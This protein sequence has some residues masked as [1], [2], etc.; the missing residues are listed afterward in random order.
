MEIGVAQEGF[1]TRPGAGLSAMPPQ[2][3]IEMASLGQL[4]LPKNLM[5]VT[6]DLVK[7]IL[8]ADPNTRLE[9]KDIM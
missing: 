1:D 9:I 4:N 8:A 6:R 5:P 7:R 2:T 3:I